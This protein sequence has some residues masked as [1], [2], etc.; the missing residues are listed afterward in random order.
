M[1][2][3]RDV[4]V[5]AEKKV[6]KS[7]G[8]FIWKLRRSH[9][10]GVRKHQCRSRPSFIAKSIL[11]IHFNAIWKIEFHGNIDSNV[12]LSGSFFIILEYSVHFESTRFV[13]SISGNLA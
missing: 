12:T 13:G 5:T 7:E 2:S 11:G 9:L 4:N 8:V 3:R 6:A 10:F 1:I